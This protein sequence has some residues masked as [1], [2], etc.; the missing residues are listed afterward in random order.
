MYHLLASLVLSLGQYKCWWMDWGFWWYW[1]FCRIDYPFSFI[2]CVRL[3]FASLILIL[4]LLFAKS[5][6][7]IEPNPPKSFTLIYCVLKFAAKHKAPLNRSALT[8][9]EEDVPSRM[10]LGSQDN[11]VDHSKI[12]C[13]VNSLLNELVVVHYNY[14]CCL[15][16]FVVYRVYIYSW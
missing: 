16:I 4:D 15:F 9:W 8:Y 13:R 3:L 11:M 6:L 5:W 12:I 14:C 1:S 2:V 10:D 7:I